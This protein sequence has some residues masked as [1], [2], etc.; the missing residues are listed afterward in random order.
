MTLYLAEK[1][2]LPI[3]ELGPDFVVFMK[4]LTP[5]EDKAA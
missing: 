4:N 2:G 1:L 3:P 5:V